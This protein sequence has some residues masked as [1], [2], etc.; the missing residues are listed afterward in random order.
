[1]LASSSSSC[2]ASGRVVQASLHCLMELLAHVEPVARALTRGTIRLLLEELLGTLLHPRLAALKKGCEVEG[3]ELTGGD[4]EG[5]HMVRS[6]NAILM[7][8]LNHACPN[9]VL[10]V[11]IGVQS[12]SFL[13]PCGCCVWMRASLSQPLCLDAPIFVSTPQLFNGVH[14]RVRQK[15]GTRGYGDGC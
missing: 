2:R 4:E 10:T 9:R 14:V 15:E 6:I 3:L 12:L 7:H 8:L 13:A 1:M 5:K 11:L